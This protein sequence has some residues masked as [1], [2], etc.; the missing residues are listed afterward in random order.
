MFTLGLCTNLLFVKIAQKQIIKNEN[1]SLSI[2]NLKGKQD[3]FVLTK[4][5]VLWSGAY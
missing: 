2:F 5:L 3:P 1:M 4:L